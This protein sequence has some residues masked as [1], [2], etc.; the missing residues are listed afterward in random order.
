MPLWF[1]REL[2]IFSLLAP[3]IYQ[4]RKSLIAVVVISLTSITLGSLGVVGYQSFLYWLPVYLMGTLLNRN[5]I[6]RMFT[7]YSHS[8]VKVLAAFSLLLYCL[9]AWFLPNGME[10]GD[11]LF[12]LEFIIFRTITPIVLCYVLW[13][14]MGSGIRERKWMHYSFFVYCM[15]APVIALLKLMYD[16]LVGRYMDVELIKYLFIISATYIGCVLLAMLLERFTP[17]FWGLLNG[18]R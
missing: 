2:I 14:I 7:L 10:K 5:A 6:T 1:I 8:K 18:K 12:S 15:H 11:T 9:W 13:L 3:V 16:K 17:K 4:I